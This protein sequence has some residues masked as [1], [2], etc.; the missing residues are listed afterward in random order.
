MHLSLVTLE[1]T[2]TV[3]VQPRRQHLVLLGKCAK[4]ALK[5]SDSVTDSNVQGSGSCTGSPRDT[6]ADPPPN[7]LYVQG[8]KEKIPGLHVQISQHP[9]SGR[10]IGYLGK[11]SIRITWRK[12]WMVNQ[13]KTFT[14]EMFNT[15]I[16]CTLTY[17]IILL[18]SHF[19]LLS[20]QCSPSWEERNNTISSHVWNRCTDTK[21]VP[22]SVQGIWEQGCLVSPGSNCGQTPWSAPFV[23]LLGY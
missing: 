2:K 23:P 1:E 20:F 10:N 18:L 22:F 15:L 17:S 9:Q 3:W 21:I 14:H 5:Q 13:S 7:K 4:T 12:R 11:N 6:G 19:L 16:S 8:T